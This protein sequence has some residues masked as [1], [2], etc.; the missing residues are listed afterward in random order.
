MEALFGKRDSLVL[1]QSQNTAAAL[2][3]SVSD[4][5]ET[6]GVAVNFPDVALI[7]SELVTNA[8]THAAGDIVLT[9]DL[10]SQSLRIEVS[11]LSAD[12]PIMLDVEPSCDGGWG[13]RLV[14]SLTSR[15]G[16][17]MSPNGKTV[18]CEIATSSVVDS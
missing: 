9:L 18:W 10:T 7:T 3:S 8:V 13:L 17:E 11:D 14:D 5:L 15:W 4:A 12:K 16:L 1:K 6:W 2:V